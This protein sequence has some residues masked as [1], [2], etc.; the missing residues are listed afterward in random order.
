MGLVRDES[1]RMHIQTP[2]M[3]GPDLCFRARSA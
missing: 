3:A 1:G 2:L